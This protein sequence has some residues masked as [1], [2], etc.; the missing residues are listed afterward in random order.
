VTDQQSVI[1]WHLPKNMTNYVKILVK[2]FFT[3]IKLEIMDCCKEAN[4]TDDTLETVLQANW[5]DNYYE[6]QY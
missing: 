2:E 6:E 4:I 3:A 5:E 1:L